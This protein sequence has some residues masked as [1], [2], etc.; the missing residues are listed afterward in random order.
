MNEFEI[1]FIVML[2][3]VMNLMFYCIYCAYMSYRSLKQTVESIQNVL[4][5]NTTLQYFSLFTIVGCIF[6]ES[7]NIGGKINRISY[8]IENILENINNL[9]V[10]RNAQMNSRANA[11]T[12][13]QK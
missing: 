13:T 10:I 5:L 1:T 8:L 9:P 4:I 3:I 6:S 11:G 12:N 7:S 2:Y